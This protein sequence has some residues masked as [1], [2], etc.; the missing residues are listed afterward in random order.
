VQ[1][2][3]L[4]VVIKKAKNLISPSASLALFPSI[5]ISDMLNLQNCCLDWS[6]CTAKCLFET[7]PNEQTSFGWHCDLATF[8]K[9]SICPRQWFEARSTHSI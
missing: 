7:K 1:H 3:V 2:G 6:P 4:Y 9:P 8:T 5:L